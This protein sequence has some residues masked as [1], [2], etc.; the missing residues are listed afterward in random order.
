MDPLLRLFRFQP[1]RTEQRASY[2]Q[3]LK[4]VYTEEGGGEGVEK[5]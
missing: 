4:Y 5:R 1:V 2:C 3:V